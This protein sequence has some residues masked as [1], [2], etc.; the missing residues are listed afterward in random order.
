MIKKAQIK[1]IM[2]LL[3]SVALHLSS[4]SQT[5]KY[6]I[7]NGKV[8]SE[9]NDN[10]YSSVQIIKNSQNAIS[11][12]IPEDGRFRLELEY[13]A[14]YKLIFNKKGNQS[15]TIVVNTKIPEKAVNSSSNFSHFLMA[16]KLFAD[17][18]NPENLNSGNHVQYIS[19]SP[20]KDCFTRVPTILDV[21]Y[22]EKANSN[23]N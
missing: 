1:I 21:E 10:N 16:V 22:G 8:M 7:I 11:A 18:Q 6:F 2:I 4:Q 12:Q 9:L 17:N 5:R 20:Q 13:N 15:K 19:Y 14:E 23:Q 3:L